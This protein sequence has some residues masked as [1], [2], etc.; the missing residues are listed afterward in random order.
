M[1][2]G[3]PSPASEFGGE[4]SLA[5]NGRRSRS[6]QATG[7]IM[8]LDHLRPR[9]DWAILTMLVGVAMFLYLNLFAL[10]NT[11][12][13]QAGDQVYFWVFAQRMSYGE[14]VYRDFLQFTPPGTDL[15]YLILLKLFGNRIWLPNITDIALGVALCWVCF[16][17]AR[18]IMEYRLA[19]LATFVFLVL[20][21]GGA[22]NGTHHW[23]SMLAIMCATAI[24]MQGAGGARIAAVG[25]LSALASFF[26]QTHGLFATAG[27]AVFLIA[28]ETLTKGNWRKLVSH[29]VLLFAVFAVVL[30]A[31]TAYFAFMVG[32][33][34]L[35]YFQV[36]YA[37]KYLAFGQHPLFLGLG[38]VPTW[39]SLPIV[40]Q[41]VFIYLALP[42]TYGFVLVCCWRKRRDPTF[43][44][45]RELMLLCLIGLLLLI[46]VTFSPSY[47]R[48]YAVSMPGIILLVWIISRGGRI[49]R[50]AVGLA[51]V[52]V[53]G[54]GLQQTLW[55]HHHPSVVADL[56]TGRVAAAPQVCEK[57]VWVMQHT[58]PG[59]F[60]FQGTW[61]G[62]YFPLELRN[63][64][65]LSE[66]TGYES[67]RP[68][69]VQRSIQELEQ[70]QV[71]YVLWTEYNDHAD[72]NYPSAYHLAPLRAYLHD[73]YQ[74]VQVFS[75]QDE[76]WERIV[77]HD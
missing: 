62:V 19:L 68:Q 14:H 2:L 70:K 43:R 67:T 50:Y 53:V 32:L 54:L 36:T 9:M 61:P 23:F 10:P 20:V 69:D 37:R 77:R 71:R 24:A 31:L 51:W 46:E 40:A 4:Y 6:V 15:L 30:A 12:F 47:L 8:R 25:A 18:Q 65:F 66:I 56:P 11:P 59:Q 34:Q 29:L 21:Y 45:R 63:P 44:N 73:R 22:L 58:Q 5:G 48:L 7:V 49:G 76:I 64:V 35:W 72:P 27:F 17:V 3:T 52:G 75:D 33:K 16:R 74:R 38:V 60:F 28:E 1:N 42:M 57:L 13:L 39:R 55:R 26:T 41:R